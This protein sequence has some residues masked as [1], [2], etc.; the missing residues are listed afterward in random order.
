MWT[1]SVT[2]STPAFE[3]DSLGS[4][5]SRSFPPEEVQERNFFSHRTNTFAINSFRCH[6]I[7][8]DRTNVRG[9]PADADVCKRGTQT[10]AS[11]SPVFG[12]LRTVELG[13]TCTPVLLII[14]NFPVAEL[15]PEK[16]IGT[17]TSLSSI[18]LP[19]IRQCVKV[20]VAVVILAQC[21]WIDG[22]PFT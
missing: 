16:A 7:T 11:F 10:M 12:F 4:N 8:H 20:G 14:S 9:C 2:V 1:C 15:T 22:S 18:R 5:P 3:V 17:W 21:Y 6:H 13:G 19:A